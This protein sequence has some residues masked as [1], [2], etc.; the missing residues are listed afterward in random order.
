MLSALEMNLTSSFLFL[1]DQVEYIAH[2]LLYSVLLL[3]PD[4]LK[5]LVFEMIYNPIG[6]EYTVEKPAFFVILRL[7]DPECAMLSAAS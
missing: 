5:L 6:L 1:S 2:L 3:L 7:Q 4:S